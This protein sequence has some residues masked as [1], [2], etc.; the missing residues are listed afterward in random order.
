MKRNFL[1]FALSFAAMLPFTSC[2]EDDTENEN[3]GNAPKENQTTDET[4]K[5]STAADSKA[6]DLGLPSGTLWAQYNVGATK[7]EEYGDYFA[8]GETAAK[9]LYSPKTYAMAVIKDGIVESWGKYDES[10]ITTL[11]SDDDAATANWGA[12]WRTPTVEDFVELAK[13]CDLNWE[14]LNGVSG[15]K[16]EASN[17]NWI[18]L[19]AAGC[20]K[21]ETGKAEDLL[22]KA[23]E[24]G[25]YWTNG[26]KKGTFGNEAYCAD[27]YSWDLASDGALSR[28]FGAS[29]RPV[30]SK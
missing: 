18:F 8:W 25:Y 23:G 28:Y 16:V 29:V 11:L 17:G 19:P 2:D 20:H 3:G 6:V 10:G 4:G 13:Y 9:S 5:D 12:G 15:Y 1:V 24:R 14:T 27:F 7:A 21:L 26:L 30:K 22:E